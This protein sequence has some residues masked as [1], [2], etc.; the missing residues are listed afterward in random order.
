MAIIG[1]RVCCGS[2]LEIEGWP[3]T[4]TQVCPAVDT[5]AVDPGKKRSRA[6]MESGRGDLAARQQAWLSR[7]SSSS[8]SLWRPVKKYRVSAKQW[9]QQLDNQYRISGD[10]PGLVKFRFV[11]GQAP[12]T[13]WRRFPFAAIGMD[14]GSDGCSALHGLQYLFGCCIEGVPDGAHGANRSMVCA[15]K[16]S[17]LFGLILLWVVSVNLLHGPDREDYRYAQLREH[18]QLLFERPDPTGVPLFISMA[19]RII[20]SLKSTGAEFVSGTS[21]ELQAWQMLRERASFLK[22]GKRASMCR[23][24]VVAAT[25]KEHLPFW[26]I[27]QFERTHVA[28]EEDFVHNST[29]VQ[30][31]AMRHISGADVPGEG[32]GV[33]Y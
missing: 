23:F 31:F 8:I 20:A 9:A 28:L 4:T 6:A 13:D 2:S 21:E 24:G 10:S 15:L 18:M 19:P 26:A 32:V 11:E 29:F 27:E 5:E 7:R 30:Q 16:A 3:A 17:G 25:L 1:P 22:E 33:S 12:W 14:L